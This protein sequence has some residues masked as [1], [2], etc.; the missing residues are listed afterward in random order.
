MQRQKPRVVEIHR[1]DDALLASRCLEHLGRARR[2]MRG[3]S[4]TTIDPSKSSAG[5]AGS[6][7]QPYQVFTF[8][9]N[10][11]REIFATRCGPTEQAHLAAPP[12]RGQARS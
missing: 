9:K 12:P 2:R 4:T 7:A 3:R 6:A 1:D 10:R 11:K 8:D 5:G